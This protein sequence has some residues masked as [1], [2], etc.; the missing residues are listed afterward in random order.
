[1]LKTVSATTGQEMCP[2]FIAEQKRANYLN[3]RGLGYT[4]GSG[5]EEGEEEEGKEERF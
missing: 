2:T 4:W 5:A 1:M 3:R